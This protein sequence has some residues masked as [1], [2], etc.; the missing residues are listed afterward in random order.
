[1]KPVK[2]DIKPPEVLQEING[3]MDSGIGV[4]IGKSTKHLSI[5]SHKLI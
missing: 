2:R 5:N 4:V 3:S 1:M